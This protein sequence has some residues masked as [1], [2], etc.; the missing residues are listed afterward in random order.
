MLKESTVMLTGNDRFEGFGIELI[1]N[2][3]DMLG[4]NYTFLLQDDG[5]YGVF[6]QT[7]QQWDGMLGEV[8]ANVSKLKMKLYIFFNNFILLAC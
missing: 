5:A 8:L 3:A 7:T 6:N 1:E 4:F 2:L